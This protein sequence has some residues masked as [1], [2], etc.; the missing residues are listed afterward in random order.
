MNDYVLHFL[1]TYFLDIS[2][3]CHIATTPLNM[4]RVCS[5][6]KIALANNIT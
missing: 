2:A 6:R 3:I 4:N 5:N 1:L